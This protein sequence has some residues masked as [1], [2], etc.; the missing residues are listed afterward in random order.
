MRSLP[1]WLL[2][3]LLGGGTLAVVAL[4]C[5]P[6]LT[7]LPPVTSVD[8]DRAVREAREVWGVPGVAVAVVRDG[9]VIYLQ[10]HGV[11]AVGRNDP[12]TPDTVFPIAS[13]TKAFTTAAM[14]MLVEEGRMSWDDPV[15]K[16]VPYFRLR[17]PAADVDVRLRDLVTHRTGLLNHDLLWYRSPLSQEELIRR[18]AHL[19]PNRPFRTAFQYQSTMF[20]TA[21]RAVESASGRPWG[22]FVQTRLFEPLGMKSATVTTAAAESAADRATGHRLI[23]RSTQLEPWYRMEQPD[24]AGSICASVRDLAAWASFQL[25]DGEWQGKRLLSAA[26]ME[27]LH[28]PQIALRLE[29][30]TREMNPETRL[31]SYG[32]GWL[33]YDH[34]GRLLWAHAGAIDGFRS[35][36]TLVPEEKLAIVLLSNLHQTPMNLPLSNTLLDLLL[37]LPRK[38]WNAHFVDLELRQQRK[39]AEAFHARAARRQPGTK[40]SR[41]LTAYVGKYHHPGYGDSEA[42]LENG[43]LVWTWNGHRCPLEHYHFDTFLPQ[44]ELLQDAELQFFLGADGEV[45]RLHVSG[46]IGV[47]FQRVSPR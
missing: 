42:T 21:G 15:R 24:A 31:M 2:L 4:I 44:Y 26:S 33:I 38:D 43:A 28:T 20:T 13:C 45:E 11:R 19:E 47:D 25:G 3:G 40:P 46:A 9:E 18:L 5:W 23:G 17:D 36:I 16:H 30:K 14:A 41:D 7:A 29:G 32:L 1:R 35:Y 27:E 37:G 10:G 39:A 12:I 8:L 6:R 34:R 22:E